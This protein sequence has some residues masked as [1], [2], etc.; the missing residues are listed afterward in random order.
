MKINKPLISKQKFKI[1]NSR[2]EIDQKMQFSKTLIISF[3]LALVLVSGQG[4]SYA[5]EQTNDAAAETDAAPSEADEKHTDK[6]LSL[7]HI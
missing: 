2:F 5:Q 4:M 1:R 3:V 6:K 7:I